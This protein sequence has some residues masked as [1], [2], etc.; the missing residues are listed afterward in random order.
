MRPIP[1]ALALAAAPLLLLAA[2]A[3]ACSVTADY[4]QPTNL[5]LAA[6][7]NAIVLGEVVGAAAFLFVG[8]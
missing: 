5:E 4:R 1:T 2:P 6:E 3:D 8:K 7:A